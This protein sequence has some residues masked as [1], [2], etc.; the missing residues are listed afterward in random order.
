MIWR[1]DLGRLLKYERRSWGMSKKRLARLAHV[2][3][4]TVED[5]ENG[6]VTDPD[7]SEMLNICDVLDSSV[8]YYMVKESNE[9][10]V[11]KGI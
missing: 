5:I 10:K 11:K 8:F 3:V 9:L 7:F 6:I 2:D 4:E 1:N